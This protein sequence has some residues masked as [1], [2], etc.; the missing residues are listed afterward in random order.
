MIILI[1]GPTHVGKTNIAQK[2]LEKFQYPYV[3][4][5]HIKMGLIRSHYT[6]LTPD[7]DEK[8]TDYLW[9][10]TREMVKTAFENKQNLIIEGCYIPF[11]WENDFEDEYLENIQYI[12]LCMSERY[13][14][15]HFTDIQQYASCIE[16]RLDDAY[17]T[18]DMIKR[19]NQRFRNGCATHHV[20]YILI[21]E[22][23]WDAIDKVLASIG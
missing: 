19:E 4:Q 12:C 8:M 22:N 18:L 17:C 21:E 2:L 3:S 20:D 6:E 7:D 14:E 15:N 5:D 9:P 23:Y 10:I 11:N 13:I 1:T 16:S